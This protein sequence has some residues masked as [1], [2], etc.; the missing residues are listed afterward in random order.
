MRLP[1]F[2]AEA[3]LYRTSRQYLQRATREG[4]TAFVVPALGGWLG[5]LL[6]SF[7]C[8]LDFLRCLDDHPRG[9]EI[10]CSTPYEI[11][12]AFCRNPVNT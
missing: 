7:G 6:C 1:A 11:C 4:G 2:T 3:S 12:L 8:Y 10:I 5:R 9:G